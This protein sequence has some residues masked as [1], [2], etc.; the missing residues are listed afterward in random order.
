MY[1]LIKTS[2]IH[3]LIKKNLS[4]INYIC[5]CYHLKGSNWIFVKEA[6]ARYDRI[7][8]ELCHFYKVSLIKTGTNTGIIS[9]WSNTILHITTDNCIDL[10]MYIKKNHL[11]T[12]LFYIRKQAILR[13]KCISDLLS[14]NI[15]NS[16][17]M[18]CLKYSIQYKNV[19]TQHFIFFTSTL[20]MFY[21]VDMN[22]YRDNYIFF[23]IKDFDSYSIW[24]KT[25]Y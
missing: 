13:Y 9:G 12:A 25:M 20:N 8:N 15:V 5:T 3:Y 1:V 6:T 23:N 19:S 21:D 24:L 14:K 22:F 17:E 10:L 11:Y 7:I 4:I 2:E 16:A 18:S